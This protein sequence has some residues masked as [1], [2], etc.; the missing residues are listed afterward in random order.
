MRPKN[1]IYFLTV[2]TSVIAICG[3]SKVSLGGAKPGNKGQQGGQGQGD[4]KSLTGDWRLAFQFNNQTCNST[5]HL[6]QNGTTFKGT[7]EDG[8]NGMKFKI[9]QGTIRDDQVNFFKKYAKSP[10][11]E[12]SGKFEIVTDGNYHGPF[13][14]GDYTT[15]NNGNIISSQWQ[16]DM[17]LPTNNPPPQQ[18]PQ[19]QQQ[20]PQE[21]QPPPGPPPPD[22]PPDLSGKWNV[23]YEYNFKTIHSTMFLE[24][25]GSRIGGHGIDTSTK[26]TFTIEKGW[27]NYPKLTLVRKYGASPA[28]GKG[29]PPA[30]AGG[31][32]MIF[33]ADV[34]WIS[35]ADYQG[36]YLHGK[37]NG[38]GEW[39]GQLVK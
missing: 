5:M 30:A 24:Q 37:T 11:V 14:S 3:C 34:S 4:Q 20:Q 2:L 36:P 32:T 31:K 17:D 22:H 23:G 1:F 35:E 21:Q 25:D 9:E 19:Q 6:V 15:A 29:K 28:K 18:Q 10:P 39:E 38:G 8:E 12:Y 16:A 26:E 13:M 7:G 27:Y 33:K